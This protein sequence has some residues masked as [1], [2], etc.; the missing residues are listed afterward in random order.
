MTQAFPYHVNGDEVE[1]GAVVLWLL[2]AVSVVGIGDAGLDL[3]LLLGERRPEV[4]FHF[5]EQDALQRRRQEDQ[6]CR[7]RLQKY[8]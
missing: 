7:G 5:H 6:C 3:H 2:V 1:V 8:A 4:V